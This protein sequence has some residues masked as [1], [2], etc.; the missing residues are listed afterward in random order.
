MKFGVRKPSIKKRVRARTT[1]K[2]K[3]AV[4]RSISPVY[5]KKGTGVVRDPKK[6]AYGKVY[7]KTSVGCLV[8][9][10]AAGT[11]IGTVISFI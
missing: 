8:P 2:A 4:K 7:N 5:G 6:A 3:R 11:A 1:G 9:L 10:I